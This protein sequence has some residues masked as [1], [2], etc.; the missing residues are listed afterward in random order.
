MHRNCN[1]KFKSTDKIRIVFDNLKNYDSY[2][3]WGQEGGGKKPPFPKIYDT[4]P[5]MVKIWYGYALPKKDPKIYESRD[6][7]LG[8]C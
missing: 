6:T 7:H 4:Y 5:T 1:I 3:E 2:H 8:P